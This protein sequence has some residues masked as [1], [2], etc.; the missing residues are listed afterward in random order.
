MLL[1]PPA[2]AMPMN[3]TIV[4]QSSEGSRPCSTDIAHEPHI[5]DPFVCEQVAEVADVWLGDLG[6]AGVVVAAAGIAH[7]QTRRLPEM[8]V[9]D[10]AFGRKHR[11]AGI[12]LDEKMVGHSESSG[13]VEQTVADGPGLGR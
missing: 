4:A 9:D 3:A 10:L 8:I 12:G 5:F 7:R 11:T 13:S 2:P 1:S 6:K